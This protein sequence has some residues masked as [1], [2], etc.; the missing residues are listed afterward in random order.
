ML[1]GEYIFTFFILEFF[2]PLISTRI[3][4]EILLTD[5]GRQHEQRSIVFLMVFFI[6][7]TFYICIIISTD[8]QFYFS[9][10]SFRHLTHI[11]HHALVHSLPTRSSTRFGFRSRSLTHLGKLTFAHR[12]FILLDLLFFIFRPF[13]VLIDIYFLFVVLFFSEFPCSTRRA[14]K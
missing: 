6:I 4:F 7:T 11:R 5:S 10:R 3:F 13:L 9:V 12:K 14:R 8:F 1:R 2:D